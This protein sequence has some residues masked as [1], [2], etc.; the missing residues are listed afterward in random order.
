M[1]PIGPSAVRA[2][3]LFV[4]P[5]DWSQLTSRMTDPSQPIELEVGSGKGL[6]LQQAAAQRP[7]HNFIGVE[8]SGKFA[9][10]AAERIARHSLA[11][12]Q[13][14][15]GD[16]EAFLLKTVPDKSV[17]AVHVYFPDPWWRRKHKKRRV[18]NDDTLAAIERILKPQGQFHFWTDVLDYY[19]L[20]C[21]HVIERMSLDGPRYVPERAATHDLDYTTHFERRARRNL[22]PI[23]RQSSKPAKTL[24]E[25]SMSKD[26]N[27]RWLVWMCAILAVAFGLRVV[28]ATYWHR[29]ALASD[30][31]FRLGDSDSYWVLA[32]HIARGEPYEYGSPDASIFRA[33]LY[34]IV[35]AP[36]T[37]IASKSDA[38]YWAR[39]FGC[40]GGTLTVWLVMRLAAQVERS[41]REVQDNAGPTS[42]PVPSVAALAAGL[43]AAIY[44]GAI[45]MSIV[46]LSEA[47][48]CPLMLMTLLGWHRALLSNDTK[49][50]LPMSFGAGA[51]SGLAILARP[52]WLLFMP[53]AGILVL[54]LSRRRMHQLAVLAVMALGCVM[55]MSPW[56]VRN[57]RI[58]GRLVPTT[59]QVG[60]SLYDGLHAGA[61]GG[62]DENME[63]VNQFIQQQRRLDDEAGLSRQ[64]S[65]EQVAAHSTFEYRLN[66]SMNRAA[67]RW[68]GENISGTIRLALVKFGRTWSLWPSAGEVGSTGLRTALTLGCY[69]IVI[70]A[71]WASRSVRAPRASKLR[72]SL[73]LCWGPA[74][75]FTLLHMVFV[76]SIRYR[77]PAVLVL[78]ALAG[79]SFSSRIQHGMLGHRD[80]H[81]S[82]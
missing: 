34:P 15:R 69:G 42:G 31:V 25:D 33:P 76:G 53:L 44:P 45:G 2:H 11:N 36:F 32:G 82:G 21:K 51:A 59:L 52:S 60:P 13:M 70:L 24:T 39:I 9:N 35:L 41:L 20:I 50:V 1:T 56:W 5:L 43:L 67:L 18:L 22:Q 16:A 71:A 3:D 65:R 7:Q 81:A 38:V 12:V 6:F 62:S 68:A 64:P 80:W 29:Q 55:V 63:F 30:R 23:Y 73:A 75:Y 57:Y 27:R 28:A 78:S 77:E 26:S 48:F 40:I 10:R 8:L 47:I 58:T 74:V 72:T 4:E 61:S 46:V 66:A 14:L 49:S 79:C 54:L 17:V 37:W 19:E